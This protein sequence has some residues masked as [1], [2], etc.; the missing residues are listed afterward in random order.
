MTK[1][2][3][4][5]GH[6]IDLVRAPGGSPG[7]IELEAD[8]RRRLAKKLCPDCRARERSE[9]TVDFDHEVATLVAA[10]WTR[11]AAEH[12]A[13]LRENEQRRHAGAD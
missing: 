13:T 6:M 1:T 4:K 7:G 2:E 10:G 8:A 11:E 12:H 9:L 3:A 5:C